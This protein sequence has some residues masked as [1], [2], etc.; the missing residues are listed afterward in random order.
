MWFGIT[1]VDDQQHALSAIVRSESLLE[2]SSDPR[3]SRRQPLDW[4]WPLVAVSAFVVASPGRWSR[5]SN[6]EPRAFRRVTMLSLFVGV[7][8]SLSAPNLL[9]AVDVSV[10]TAAVACGVV[11]VLSAIGNLLGWARDERAFMALARADLVLLTLACGGGGRSVPLAV[12]V[13]GALAATLALKRVDD[14]VR[15]WFAR[16]AEL[17]AVAVG[18]ALI[19]NG[20]YSV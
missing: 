4:S 16:V 20:V 9:A 13:V 15:G 18:V 10:P 7:I 1:Q 2:R 3:P 12:G 6:R 5:A 14:D 11:V 17:S 8:V 19:V